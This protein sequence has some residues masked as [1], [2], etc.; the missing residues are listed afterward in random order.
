MH[1]YPGMAQRVKTPKKRDTPSKGSLARRNLEA[2][3]A[4]RRFGSGRHSPAPVR[5]GSMIRPVTPQYNKPGSY[6]EPEALNSKLRGVNFADVGDKIDSDK[7]DYHIASEDHKYPVVDNNVPTHG[8]MKTNDSFYEAEV[9]HPVYRQNS[10]QQIFPRSQLSKND[11][12]R[13]S[14]RELSLQKRL[15]SNKISSTRSGLYT[16]VTAKKLESGFSSGSNPEIL[17][18]KQDTIQTE[19][20][21]LSQ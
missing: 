2:R 10:A 18:N 13:P 21:R 12:I 17:H 20:S 7:S 11:N 14:H 8:I 5:S 1:R 9:T 6:G 15:F 3:Q 4:V 19:V 16:G